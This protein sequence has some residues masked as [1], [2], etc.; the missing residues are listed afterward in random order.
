MFNDEIPLVIMML[1][2]DSAVLTLE[3]DQMQ[4]HEHGIS[5]PG[6][7]HPYLDFYQWMVE[8]ITYNGSGGSIYHGGRLHWDGE[9]RTTDS[10]NTGM[11]VTGV[12]SSYRH[13][14]ETRPK[15][16]NVIYI[17]RVY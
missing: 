11:T 8:S 15:N 6:H 5:D 2:P 17:I 4:D 10:H 12:S 9:D 7:S 13:G 3:E 14:D 16:M 1:G